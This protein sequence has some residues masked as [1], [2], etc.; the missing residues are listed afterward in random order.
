MS[1]YNGEVVWRQT[2]NGA[3]AHINLIVAWAWIVV[4]F[5]FG[6][7]LGLSFQGEEWLGGYSSF[8][9]RLLRLGHIS[10]FGLGFINLMF[11]VTVAIVP[12]SGPLVNIASWAFVAG[13]I[14]M[15]ICC[16]MMMFNKRFQPVFAVPVTSLLLAGILTIWKVAQ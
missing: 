9:R 11:Y 10:F 13:A 12:L 8:K 7:F 3:I 2:V 16:L 14:T 15:P 5:L 6:M 4:G 1:Q